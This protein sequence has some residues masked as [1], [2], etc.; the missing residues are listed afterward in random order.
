MCGVLGVVGRSPVIGDIVD[1]LL[2][3]QHR[4]QDAAGAATF[5][6]AAFR[7][8]KKMGL[9]REVFASAWKADPSAAAGPEANKFYAAAFS[10]SGARVVVRDWLETTIPEAQKNLARSDWDGTP[11]HIEID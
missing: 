9:V 3:L 2:F 5:D 7:T 1:G 10:A 4:G 8:H 6:G 11:L